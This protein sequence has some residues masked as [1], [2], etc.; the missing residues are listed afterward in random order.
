MSLCSFAPSNRSPVMSVATTVRLPKQP[1]RRRAT[2]RQTPVDVKA[3]HRVALMAPQK[4]TFLNETGGCVDERDR[5][6]LRFTTAF[7]AH[8]GSIEYAM[9]RHRVVNGRRGTGEAN[10]SRAEVI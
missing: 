2:G 10:V 1:W 4:Q 5:M 9:T 8:A 3:Q 7:R 6:H